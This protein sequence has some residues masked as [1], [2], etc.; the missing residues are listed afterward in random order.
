MDGF[1]IFSVPSI[2]SSIE[3]KE[4]DLVVIGGGI[5]GSGIALDAS[6]RG[7][8]VLLLE[9]HDFAWGTSSRSTKLI[10]GG[11]RYLAQFEFGLVREV[12]VERSIVY[13]NAR[14]IVRPEKMLLPFF[15][16]G[17][18]GKFATSIGLKIYD[19]LA[20]VPKVEHRIMLKK[21]EVLDQEPLLSKESLLGGG[22]YFEYR[23]DDARLT[24]EVLKAAVSNGATCLNYCPFVDFKYKENG[25]IYSVFFKSLS[26]G[27]SYQVRTKKVINAAGP[28]VDQIRK[29]DD[30]LKNKRLQLTKGIHLVFDRNRFPI[31]IATY[32]DAPDGRMIFVIPRFE[33]VYAGTTDTVYN[34]DIDK[35]TASKEDVE[36]ILNSLNSVYPN[37]LLE[38]EDIESS[39]S[40]LRPLIHEDGKSPSELSRKDEIF[41]SESGL[42]SIAGGKLTGYRKMSERIVDLI[43]KDL[44]Q[45]NSKELKASKTLDYKI[46]GGNFDSEE[47][48]NQYLKTKI[49]QGEI[50]E[51]PYQK[52]EQWVFRYGTSTD[53]II[54]NCLNFKE[55]NS[56]IDLP[57]FAEIKYC[58]D[59]EMVTSLSDYYIR[60]T[61]MAF[62]NLNE[63]KKELPTA[64]E[65][66][67]RLLPE[68]D[69]DKQE[70]Q[71]KEELDSL[72]SFR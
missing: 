61:G 35:P 34:D 60:R 70:E 38:I 9:K 69:L 23:T 26:T 31:S 28:W 49:S 8:S 72:T 48:L 11:L 7:L 19:F 56:K 15:K 51:I 40:G 52:V 36:Y 47:S 2:L 55:V 71:L 50:L 39:W 30:S 63:I 33:K 22:K 24:T 58:I 42:I 10:H 66:F 44:G 67:R 3:N 64:I 4:F 65:I 17:N 43:S 25:K 21:E 27:E 37:I 45:V 6:L 1:N 12:G 46:S 57:V 59:N 18:L 16:G 41:I 5:T 14:H 29:K 20:D 13:Q 54:D 68:A 53:E 32:F 62:F